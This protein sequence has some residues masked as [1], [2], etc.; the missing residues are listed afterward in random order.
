MIIAALY[1]HY[2]NTV[3]DLPPGIAQTAASA[4]SQTNDLGTA[5]EICIE[6]EIDVE[7]IDNQDPS[8]QAVYSWVHN[9]V[10]QQTQAS[11]QDNE[12]LEEPW[13]NLHAQ[14]PY[15][16]QHHQYAVPSDPSVGS[17][18]WESSPMPSAPAAVIV[19]V[20]DPPCTSDTTAISILQN[21][22]SEAVPTKAQRQRNAQMELRK[23][24]AN[25]L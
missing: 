19:Q 17:A 4:S 8:T 11:A 15:P 24:K 5:D 14:Q 12:I 2:E 13:S 1:Q 21:P 7:T 18:I 16:V 22:N 25:A 23:R 3:V 10:E 20:H 9:N 6:D